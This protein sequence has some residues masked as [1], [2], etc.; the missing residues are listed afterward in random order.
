MVMKILAAIPLL[1]LLTA[2]IPFDFSIKGIEKDIVWDFK[3][4]VETLLPT[5]SHTVDVMDIVTMSKRR[6]ELMHKMLEGQG[7]NYE[8]YMKQ[9]KIAVET[10]KAIPYDPRLGVTEKEWEE[11]KIMFA[12]MSDMKATSSGTEKV[13]VIRNG[14]LV[15]FKSAGKLAS[16]NS[17]IID[18]KTMEIKVDGHVLRLRDTINIRDSVHVFKSPWKGYKFHYS[19][20]NTTLPATP[21]ELRKI[22]SQLY[23]F[24]L[25]CMEKTRKTYI[26]MK[27]Q[28]MVGGQIT[29]SYE[30]PVIFQ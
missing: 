10:K 1:I 13:E 21:E 29:I 28:E 14:D 16:L 20:G 11:L 30:I 4:D 24:T 19:S 12:D 9:L 8:W 3:K 17:T 7:K 18:I 27:G 5:G 6:E 15:S 25:G 22:S 26:V 2:S 23:D